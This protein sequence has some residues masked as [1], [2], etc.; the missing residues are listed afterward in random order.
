MS[1]KDNMRRALKGSRFTKT[2]P[3]SIEEL[4]P[5]AGTIR[6]H[7][8]AL[9]AAHKEMSRAIEKS[10]RDRDRG[11][12]G[13]E[14]YHRDVAEA[15]QRGEAVVRKHTDKIRALRER[16]V[17]G[18]ET[19]WNTVASLTA[20]ASKDGNYASLLKSL[21]D[22]ARDA[23]V[24]QLIHMRDVEKL[25]LAALIFEDLRPE[26]VASVPMPE[27]DEA[28]AFAAAA[29]REFGFANIWREKLLKGDSTPAKAND[30]LVVQM[31]AMRRF[32]TEDVAAVDAA[33]VP[34]TD[35]SIADWRKARELIVAIEKQ[36][37]EPATASDS[38]ERSAPASGRETMKAALDA[39]KK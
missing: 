39:A 1:A 37:E 34:R 3:P 25:A 32:G 17:D 31:A 13:E 28:K 9:E 29:E 16:A 21:P 23:E 4:R 24:Q 35:E 8:T 27:I 30:Q 38:T 6:A 15:R 19:K 14:R 18:F 26:I 7:G 20:K 11:E 36:P 33:S 22:A 12:I 10:R 5:I 2:A